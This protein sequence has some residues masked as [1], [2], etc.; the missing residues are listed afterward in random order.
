MTTCAPSRT[1]SPSCT[2][3]PT[4]SPGARPSGFRAAE[5]SACAASLR[6]PALTS[7]PYDVGGA[8]PARDTAKVH[9]EPR[10]PSHELVIDLRVGGDDDH[11]VGVG[12]RL[13]QR[14][15]L[16]RRICE[17]WDVRVVIGDVGT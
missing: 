6:S 5:A 9:D 16:Q 17:G 11:E 4:N 14:T 7:Q 12:D 8:R 13:D 1:A 10:P 2:P 15:T 3:S